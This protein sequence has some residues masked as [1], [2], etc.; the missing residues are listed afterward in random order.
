MNSGEF[1]SHVTKIVKRCQ[2]L[3]AD[4]EERAI[5]DAIILDMSSQEAGDKAINLMNEVLTVDFLMNQLEIEDCNSHH[6]SLSQL[7][8]TTSVNF[9]PFDHRQNK[10]G[11]NQK[12]VRNGKQQAQNNSR[13]QRSSNSGHQSRKL[14][15]MEDKC[16][17]CGKH[18]HQPG[19]RCPAKNVTK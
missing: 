13:E 6:K 9:V 3:N 14:Q 15:G 11:K 16:M 8:S 7:D 12:N 5:R 18:E 2:F 10:R 19:K 1:H 4:A 17:K